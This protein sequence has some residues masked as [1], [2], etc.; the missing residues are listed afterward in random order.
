M[1]V[2]LIAII[3]L[4]LILLSSLPCWLIWYCAG[5]WLPKRYV[6]PHGK[7]TLASV[8]LA[9]ATATVLNVEL[10]AGILSVPSVVILFS[11]V[12]S[13]LLLSLTPF[14]KKLRKIK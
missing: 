12:W 7:M 1:G 6:F 11:V 9:L 5:K 8:L 10:E 13:L 3:Y 4:G 14:L 2:V